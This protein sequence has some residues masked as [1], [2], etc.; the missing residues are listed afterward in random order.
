[1]DNIQH[2]E[3][4]PVVTA[5]LAAAP[6]FTGPAAVAEAAVGGAHREVLKLRDGEGEDD[7]AEP[8]ESGQQMRR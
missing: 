5:R 8:A 6:H 2:A 4:A 3:V 7:A 1:M